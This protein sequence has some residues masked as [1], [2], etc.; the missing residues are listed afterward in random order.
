MEPPTAAE[1]QQQQLNLL[2]LVM[3]AHIKFPLN[4]QA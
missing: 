3:A 4:R 2:P 1:L